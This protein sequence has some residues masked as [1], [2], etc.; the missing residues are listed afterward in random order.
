[1]IQNPEN[2]KLFRGE[3]TRA[4]L[5]C[6]FAV[7]VPFWWQHANGKRC[8][9]FN[10]MVFNAVFNLILLGLFIDFHWRTYASAKRKQ[11]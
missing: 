10:A 7:S 8:S 3:L 6:S 11:K 2:S 1:M 5:L 4:S 9:G